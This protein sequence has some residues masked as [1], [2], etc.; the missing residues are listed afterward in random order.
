MAQGAEESRDTLA[1]D[2]NKDLKY[3]RGS[4][5]RKGTLTARGERIPIIPDEDKKELAPWKDKFGYMNQAEAE[6]NIPRGLRVEA[7]SGTSRQEKKKKILEPAHRGRTFNTR[8]RRKDDYPWEEVQEEYHL[9][10]LS[11]TLLIKQGKQEENDHP[12]F[13]KRPPRVRRNQKKIEKRDP[14]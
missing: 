7:G 10:S 11:L 1:R 5:I 12:A 9:S 6:P 2:F 14:G 3:K 13:E 4:L 8:G